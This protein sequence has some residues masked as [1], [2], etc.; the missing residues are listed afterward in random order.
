MMEFAYWF[1]EAV[2]YREQAQATADPG[3]QREFLEL[4]EVCV[5]F[6]NRLEERATGG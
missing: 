6:A 1:D 3:E 2:K 4:A 5:D